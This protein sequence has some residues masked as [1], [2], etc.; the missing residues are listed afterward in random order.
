MPYNTSKLM[1]MSIALFFA[2]TLVGQDCNHP[3]YAALEKF[4]SATGGD[5]WTQQT[6][7]LTDC[8]PCAWFGVNCDTEGRVTTI[9][10]RGNGLAG[11]LPAEIGDL[12]HLRLLNLG[13]N[14][15]GGALP[16]SLFT[17][18]S[19]RDI[20]LSGNRISGQL[21]TTV[22]E[23]LLLEN[24][25]LDKNL[26]TGDLPSTLAGFTRMVIM[27]LNDNDFSGAI[28]EGLGD[29]PFI[30]NLD[31]SRNDFAGCFPVDLAA[32]CGQERILFGDNPKLSWS[33][34][35]AEFCA[36]GLLDEAQ[37]GAPCNDGDPDT[38][39]DEI[40][41]DC[42]CGGIEE[43]NGLLGGE[44]IGFNPD[45]ETAAERILRNRSG[46]ADV[47]V[48]NR[49][50]EVIGLSVYPNPLVGDVLTVQLPVGTEDVQLRLVSITGRVMN[51]I[52]AF[53]PVTGM[54]LPVLEAGVYLLEA[55][56]AEGRSVRRVIVQ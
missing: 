15:V 9:I 37:I 11:V 2:L 56:T 29:L 48:L 35:F 10:L 53:G 24:L 51:E 8:E 5:T 42:G 49:V 30:F 43:P 41:A 34:D 27:T 52:A 19:L 21:P 4:Y 12:D 14:E 44:I 38:G 39:G 26:L 54:Q 31:L 23:Q 50:R 7:W 55:V 25:R 22:G 33:G 45:E 3:D 1:A 32:F 28:P 16:A 13:Y 18:D 6:G 17:I 20:N 47:P 36:I 40:T 46:L